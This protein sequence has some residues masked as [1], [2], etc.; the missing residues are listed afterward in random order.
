M[1]LVCLWVCMFS[2]LCLKGFA[3]FGSWNYEFVEFLSPASIGGM[4]IY[5]FIYLFFD[6]LTSI[7]SFLWAPGT[8]KVWLTV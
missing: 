8:E 6:V 3:D 7:F 2:L 5:L 4:V 1:P